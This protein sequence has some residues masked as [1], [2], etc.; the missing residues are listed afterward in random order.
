MHV[1]FKC[2]SRIRSAKEHAIKLKTPQVQRAFLPG[3][4]IRRR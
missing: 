1:T 4:V 2:I 3:L